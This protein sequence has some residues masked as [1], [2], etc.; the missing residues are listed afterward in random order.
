M[1]LASTRGAAPA[2]GFRDAILQG[3]APDGGLYLPVEYP[4]VPAAELASWRGRSFTDVAVRLA[5]RLLD[6]EFPADVIE[7]LTGEA[8]DFPA[9]VVE[10]E[11]GRLVLELFHGPTL[12]F[13]DFGA[14]F[15]ARF[16]GQ[17][18]T[19]RQTGATI[20]VATSGDTGSAV[21]RG[22]YGVPNVRVVVLYP[23]GRISPFQESQMA[24]LGGNIVALRVPGA[25]DD[26]QRLVKAAFLDEDL[27]HLHLSSANSINVGRLLPQSFYYVSSY[28]AAAPPPAV[29]VVFSVP[30][31]NLGNL[32]A[33]IIARRLGVPVA[34]FVAATNRNATLPEYL[35][36]GVYRARPSVPTLSNAMDVGDPNNFPRL[37][38]L[39]GGALEALRASVWGMS[40]DEDTT[41]G[42][43]REVYRRR[44]Y[45]LDPHGAVGWAAADRARAAGIVGSAPLI[46]LA[47]AHPAKFGTA[48]EQE[49]GFV[50]ELPEGHRDWAARRLRAEDLEAAHYEAFRDRLLQL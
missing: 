41:R 50:P 21:A 5:T 20:L 8:L 30:T 36:T 12:A 35:E 38:A 33:G 10:V 7:R 4:H 23:E 26:C 22:F 29:P 32:T 49:L 14:R 3:L 16:F 9:P 48:I 47:T 15:L 13:K 18:M 37:L 25:F 43:I 24:T 40:V 1:I 28:L 31:G 17:L 19:E 45:L 39:H 44:Q 6:T 27:R 11:P 34:R 2:V 46:S 42:T